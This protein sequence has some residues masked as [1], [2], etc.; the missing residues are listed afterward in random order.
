MTL[1]NWG[2]YGPSLLY[3]SALNFWM[4]GIIPRLGLQRDPYLCP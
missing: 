1:T 4:L 3:P 2:S